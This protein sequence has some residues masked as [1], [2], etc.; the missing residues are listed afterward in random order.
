MLF[1]SFYF[2]C[3]LSHL[4]DHPLFF[5]VF[6]FNNK[7]SAFQSVFLSYWVLEVMCILV[8]C[9]ALCKP[10]CNWEA[11]NAVQGTVYLGHGWFVPP[12]WNA[13]ETLWKKAWYFEGWCALS[14][15]LSLRFMK[16]SLTQW[17]VFLVSCSALRKMVKTHKDQGRGNSN[18]SHWWL[19]WVPAGTEVECRSRCRNRCYCYRLPFCW[20]V[21]VISDGW[22]I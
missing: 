9:L 20:L 19:L 18:K 13:F 11:F 1:Y 21:A 12:H 10:Y 8:H 15:S 4:G 3:V 6:C 14:L 5:F 2:Q 16:M 22:R 7:D 17:A